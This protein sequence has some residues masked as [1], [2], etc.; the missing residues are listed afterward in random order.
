MVETVF[1]TFL[2]LSQQRQPIRLELDFV[3]DRSRS[4]PDISRAFAEFPSVSNATQLE[5]YPL[6]ISKTLFDQIY[7]PETNDSVVFASEMKAAIIRQNQAR[8]LQM[9]LSTN[10]SSLVRQVKFEFEFRF[11]TTEDER[12]SLLNELSQLDLTSA[13]AESQLSEFIA[14]Q[15]ELFRRRSEF[16]EQRY[17]WANLSSYLVTARQQLAI[18]RA[19][20]T[21]KA[22]FNEVYANV[23]RLVDLARNPVW[24]VNVTAQELA[25]AR[26]EL[27]KATD[28]LNYMTLTFQPGPDGKFRPEDIEAARKMG[29]QLGNPASKAE[30][31]KGES[32]AQTPNPTPEEQA[33]EQPDENLE[34][35]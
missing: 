6:N 8:K 3:Y 10:V 2:E 13:D 28:K 33:E 35:L 17:A 23:S 7:E 18:S 20:N 24:P 11:V 26:S 29:I 14:R 1:P 19:S 22:E 12:S 31:E 21:T 5:R 15:E 27:Q 16:I 34:E 9:D 32:P 25:N 30:P 4:L